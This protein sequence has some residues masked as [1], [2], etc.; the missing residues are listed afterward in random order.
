MGPQCV[1][2]H[3]WSRQ[4]S[5]QHWVHLDGLQED[6]PQPL[7]S[8]TTISRP[9]RR[10]RGKKQSQGRFALGALMTLAAFLLLSC[11]N[12][13]QKGAARQTSEAESSGYEYGNRDD[14]EEEVDMRDGGRSM[15]WGWLKH[16]GDVSHKLVFG[17][18][19]AFNGDYVKPGGVW[20]RRSREKSC[21]EDP[22]DSQV[23]AVKDLVLRQVPE[24]AN[25]IAFTRK[26][27]CHKSTGCF[28]VGGWLSILSALVCGMF[29]LLIIQ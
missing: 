7:A 4:R 16:K 8:M 10:K 21:H 25:K 14:V 3:S 26:I 2:R 13:V 23:Q 18:N 20:E 28:K 29:Y 22:L 1:K 27:K 19:Q 6:L 9:G 17:N 12:R 24:L 5:R 11:G 15:V